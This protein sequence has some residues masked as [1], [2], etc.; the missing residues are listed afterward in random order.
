MSAD[1]RHPV[2][3][4]TPGPARGRPPRRRRRAGGRRVR[5]GLL[6]L[7]ALLALL[8]LG[9]GA[10]SAPAAGSGPVLVVVAHPDDETL[11]FGGAIEQAIAD[12]R[13]V[14]VAIVTNGAS[15]RTPLEGQV[16]G[17]AAGDPSAYANT[18]LERAAESVSALGVLGGSALPWTQNVDTTHVLFLG[19]PDG[20][21]A[22]IAAG[23]TYTDPTGL[24]HTFAAD[25]DDDPATCNGDYAYLRSGGFGHAPLTSASLAYDLRT[26]LLQFAPTDVYT[27]AV[28][29]G[30]SDHATVGRM[31]IAA[32]QSTGLTVSLHEGLVHETGDTNCMGPAALWWPNPENVSDPDLRAT[33]SEPFAAPAIFATSG[34]YVND[35][36]YMTCPDGDQPVAHDWGPLGAPTE[37]PA[38]PDTTKKA[39]AIDAYQS[40]LGT[41]G[42][43]SYGYMKGFVKSD[44]ILWTQ[45]VSAA[46][47]PVPLDWPRLSRTGSTYTV[48][49]PDASYPASAFT[50]ADTVSFQWWRCDA[51]DRWQCTAIPNAT[52]T[53]YTATSADAGLS[54][55]VSVVA[56]NSAGDSPRVFSG[57][58]DPVPTPLANTTLPA[59]A[60]FPG[61]GYGNALTVVPGVWTGVP[62][63]RLTYQWQFSFTG[64]NGPWSDA[65]G[66]TATSWTLPSEA[67][68]AWLRIAET[69]TNSG[70]SVTVDSAP[71]KQIVAIV[72]P[73]ATK[74]PSLPTS[75]TVGDAVTVTPGVWTGAPAP[76]LTYRWESS[77]D[78]ASWTAIAGATGTSYVP[79]SSL[80]GVYLRVVEIAA[81]GA[82]AVEADSAAVVVAAASGGGGGTPTP[83]PTPTPTP[84]PPVTTPAPPT[85]PPPPAPP[86]A[87][88]TVKAT[89]EQTLAPAV[90]G[91]LVYRVT[92]ADAAGHA[93][94]SGLVLDVTLPPGFVVTST[95]ASAGACAAGGPGLRCTIGSLAAGATVTVTI[96]GVVGS[97]GP[98]TLAVAARHAAADA[99]PADDTASLTLQQAPTPPPPPVAVTPKIRILGTTVKRGAVTVRV[100]ITGWRVN[101]KPRANAPTASGYWVVSVDGKAKAASRHAG[102]AV[103]KVKAGKHALRAELVKENGKRLAPRVRSQ[104]VRVTVA[105]VKRATSRG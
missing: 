98:Q 46:S 16:C 28:F 15:S 74:P 88:V 102:Y 47:A 40:Q 63:P 58:A 85:P 71:T 32:I 51:A 82:P 86:A 95:A 38:V 6:G 3:S 48:T 50:P 56:H 67:A 45:Q 44:E 79:P 81:N 10:A 42:A 65:T 13:Q 31:V 78:G 60:G 94:A 41:K 66:E 7:T 83:S 101:A 22:T 53:S 97:N 105:P 36:G 20:A 99:N 37:T 64:P 18:A 24:G 19:Y 23:G 9:F 30:H 39:Q 5:I 70:G 27:H 43:A 104:S 92:V 73:T 52:T 14:Y 89:A 2:S 26:L 17:A 103:L 84:A 12:G 4:S 33:P 49:W 1:H 75:P 35:T 69:A 8:V 80:A 90:G 11:A 96:H 68:G 76:T 57:S 87:D 29:D 93:A 61:A 21:L 25:G 55:R 62:A 77:P 59:I 91:E 100:R 72:P 34:G 54:L